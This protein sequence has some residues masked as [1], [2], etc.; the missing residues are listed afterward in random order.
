MI[1]PLIGDLFG[2]H[3]LFLVRKETHRMRRIGVLFVLFA[4]TF[5]AVP[6]FAG[7]GL[8]AGM[9]FNPEDFLIGIHFKTRPLAEAWSLV[10]SVEAGFG[11]V[12]MVAG[13]LDVHYNFKTSSKLAPYAGAG[14]TLNWFDDD[15][16]GET[17]FGGSILAGM[18]ISPRFFLEGK[19]GLGDVPDGKL[20]I[21]F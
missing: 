10:P 4:L 5:S 21:G 13:N 2:S 9:T 3:L 6:A 17:D 7:L 14:I 12:T 1:V 16:G 8:H 11:D 18:A 20:Y 15:S 19:V